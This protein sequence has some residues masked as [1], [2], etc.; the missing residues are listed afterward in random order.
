MDSSWLDPFSLLSPYIRR[1]ETN[2]LI[3]AGRDIGTACLCLRHRLLPVILPRAFYPPPP[4]PRI[5]HGAGNLSLR[6]VS[7]GRSWSSNGA[8]SPSV[9][10]LHRPRI[11]TNS[12]V[13]AAN[14]SLF[15]E[16]C[17]TG[18][19]K[20]GDEDRGGGQK[21]NSDPA[22]ERWKVAR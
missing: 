22:Y 21:G 3:S 17:N 19:R 5:P 20:N 9:L 18:L 7:K 14:S 13:Y 10:S 12:K 2:I 8:L 1:K 16:P 6:F 11:A 15:Y 4:S